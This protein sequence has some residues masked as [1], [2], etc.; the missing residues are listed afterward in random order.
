MIAMHAKAPTLT[1]LLTAVSCLMV[2]MTVTEVRNHASLLPPPVGTRPPVG[3]V[4]TAAVADAVTPTPE[5]PSSPTP[6][7]ADVPLPPST[8]PATLRVARLTVPP[9]GGLPSAVAPGPT[10]LTVESGALTVRVDGAV[11]FGPG[12][13]AAYSDTVLRHGERL[14]IPAGARHAVRNDGPTPAVALVVMIHPD[15]SPADQVID[16]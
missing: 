6:L 15:E 4:E 10:V 16:H 12:L 8:G 5:P 13:D 11:W 1:W 14:V 2:G 3:L 9:G 7:F